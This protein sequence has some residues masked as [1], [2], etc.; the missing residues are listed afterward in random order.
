MRESRGL[1]CFIYEK[2]FNF[3]DITAAG[4]SRDGANE[5]NGCKNNTR[6]TGYGRNKSFRRNPGR[7]GSRI[8]LRPYLRQ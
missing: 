8:D 2:G 1:G 4:V 3:I 6:K 5:A 7:R